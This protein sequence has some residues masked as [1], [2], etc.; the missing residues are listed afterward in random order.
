[1]ERANFDV[2]PLFI[3]ISNRRRSFTP[4][5]SSSRKRQERN[6]CAQFATPKRSRAV[7]DAINRRVSQLISSVTK[8]RSGH[9]FSRAHI[10]KY[11]TGARARERE[12]ISGFSFLDF[13]HAVRSRSRPVTKI[14]RE[15]ERERR[16][17]VEGD[18]VARLLDGSRDS[19]HFHE[20]RPNS[21]FAYRLPPTSPI[22]HRCTLIYTKRH[23]IIAPLL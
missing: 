8:S 19:S 21:L 18:E 5:V 4:L 16:Y 1:M 22:H 15:K 10:Q 13:S 9:E 2:Q 14:F 17:V 11:R 20:D 6:H 12:R 3:R 23:E 7:Y